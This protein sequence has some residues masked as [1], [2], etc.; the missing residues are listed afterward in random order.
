MRGRRRGMTAGLAPVPTAQ[1]P[2]Q[3][4]AP[5][6]GSGQQGHVVAHQVSL[7]SSGYSACRNGIDAPC[8]SAAITQRTL[9]S[10]ATPHSFASSDTTSALQDSLLP[11]QEP[12]PF[13]L[14]FP[15]QANRAPVL[16]TP[17]RVP[18]TLTSAGVRGLSR[19]EYSRK[20]TAGSPPSISSTR[21]P[22]SNT[23]SIGH[24]NGSG[25]ASAPGSRHL[26]RRPQYR[27]HMQSSCVGMGA[28]VIV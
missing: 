8:W 5:G 7:C 26:S 3:G 28:G 21:C 22:G 11:P 23:W 27:S 19:K 25:V 12:V 18:H 17:H 4:V 16:P 14:P 20:G 2:A 15:A 6:S 10:S 13:S 1:A 24:V 9:Q